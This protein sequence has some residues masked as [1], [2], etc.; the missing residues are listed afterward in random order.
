M[1]K[2]EDLIDYAVTTV[3]DCIETMKK[4]NEDYAGSGN[5]FSNFEVS[6][7]F[8]GITAVQSILL[9]IGNKGARLS[10]LLNNSK[11]PNNESIND[12]IKDLINYA[13][14]LGAYLKF[15]GSKNK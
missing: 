15:E 14:L 6:G 7:S 12:S 9:Q 11:T 3:A 8:A 10:E 1:T 2:R 4:K 13:L 5:P